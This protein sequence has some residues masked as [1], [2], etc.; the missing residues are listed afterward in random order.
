[1]LADCAP[2]P[3]QPTPRVR[4]APVPDDAVLVPTGV[5]HGLYATGN[6]PLRILLIFGK[7]AAAPG[8]P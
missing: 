5:D 1:M 4:R 3:T 6:E 8:P 7:V 2:M